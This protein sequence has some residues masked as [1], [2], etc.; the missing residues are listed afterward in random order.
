MRP[1]INWPELPYPGKDQ[2]CVGYCP[3]HCEWGEFSME[4]DCQKAQEEYWEELRD[5]KDKDGLTVH[6][7][8]NQCFIS[9]VFILLFEGG[10]EDGAKQYA[11]EMNEYLRRSSDKD[12]DIF[13]MEAM[14]VKALRDIFKNNRGSRTVRRMRRRVSGR[15]ADETIRLEE[16]RITSWRRYAKPPILDGLFGGKACH[17]QYVD[18]KQL[19][20][21]KDNDAKFDKE[22]MHNEEPKD[23]TRKFLCK[24]EM[25]DVTP[26]TK[27]PETSG[28]VPCETTHWGQWAEWTKCDKRCHPEG[29]RKRFRKCLNTCTL[30]QVDD[31]KCKG[32][33]NP[34]YDKELTNMDWTRCSPC[35]A[36]EFPTWSEWGEWA[37]VG[38]HTKYCEATSNIKM[39]RK[40][41][42][43]KAKNK[44]LRCPEGKDVEFIETSPP[45]CEADQMY[46]TG[47]ATS[48]EESITMEGHEESN[49]ESITMEGNEES[50]E[51]SISM[52]GHE[53]SNEDTITMEGHEESNEESIQETDDG[54][55]KEDSLEVTRTEIW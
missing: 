29:K 22:K 21:R 38:S 19:T 49:E 37:I 14:E 13:P 12:K 39:K 48:N 36:E 31:S 24:I 2:S 30:K 26:E 3:L 44:R 53:E 28:H 33:Y 25:C 52:E 4:E 54:E 41:V 45:K 34:I 1:I 42:C 8:N 11:K 18:K 10:F 5:E 50:N 51:D 40:R 6:A 32:F 7:I 47:E 16:M 17:R 46:M 9:D 43:V 55:I 35:P 15:Y 20:V 23:E 27:P